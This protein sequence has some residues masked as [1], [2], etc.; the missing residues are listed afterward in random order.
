V[1]V[2]V[3]NDLSALEKGASRRAGYREMLSLARDGGLDVIVAWHLDR[4]TRNLRDLEDL[5]DLCDSGA[6]SLATVQSGELD[7]T[8]ATGRMVA[9]MVGTAARAESELKGERQRAKALQL[10]QAGRPSGGG[11]RAY[12]YQPDGMTVIPAEAAI[13]KEAARRVLAGE[14]MRSVL[15]DLNGRGVPT[16]SGGAWS[17][18]VLTR[19]LGS[20]RIA[21]LREHTPRARKQKDVRRP[22][23]GTIISEAVWPAIISKTDS[24][25]LRAV[26]ANR[27]DTRHTTSPRNLLTGVLRC[28][29]CE[30]GLFSGTPTATGKRRYVCVRLPSG[31]CGGTAILR[32]EADEYVSEMVKDALCSPDLIRR[33]AGLSG[34]EETALREEL[35]TVEHRLLE[36]AQDYAREL[37]SRAE[38]DAMLKVYAERRANAEQRLRAAGGSAVLAGIS[39]DRDTL[40][41]QWCELPVSRRRGLVQLVLD[42]V[43]V[44]PAV[45]GRN[46]FDSERFDPVWRF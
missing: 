29:K 10:A 20:A 36:L 4:V 30:R 23:G 6:V 1:H 26:I 18:Q 43:W 15:F 35:A 21:G 40:D 24:E 38:R 34:E 42:R 12:G 14:S 17:A 33:M 8:T 31:G 41:A 16:V 27:H 3:D 28:A 46:T 13:I 11:S 44:R 9:R 19:V 45:R 25:R 2:F 32:E 37:I 22:A 5:V 7:L 39:V